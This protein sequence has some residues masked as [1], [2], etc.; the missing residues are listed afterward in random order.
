MEN[1]IYF[2]DW[3]SLGEGCGEQIFRGILSDDKKIPDQFITSKEEFE[4][5]K[6]NIAESIYVKGELEKS[7]TLKKNLSDSF[8]GSVKQEISFDNNILFICT[9]AIIKEIVFSKIFQCYLITFSEE[10][11]EK[12][13]YSA[14]IVNK[15]LDD[16]NKIN[17]TYQ[18][19]NGKPEMLITDRPKFENDEY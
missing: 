4:K 12:S 17:T 3:W 9:G 10:K 7:Y 6:E 11:V 8:M 14:A 1:Y 19:M 5:F 18:F 16:D 2:E 15:Y 13:A